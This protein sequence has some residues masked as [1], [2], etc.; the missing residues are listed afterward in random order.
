M[1]RQDDVYS[2]L[3][4][5]GVVCVGEEKKNLLEHDEKSGELSHW[6]YK[7]RTAFFSVPLKEQQK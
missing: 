2:T 3:T 5:N 1:N 6:L 7:R 4:R